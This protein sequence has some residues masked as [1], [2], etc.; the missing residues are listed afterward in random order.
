VGTG[1]G[2]LGITAKLELPGASVELLDLDQE[3]LGVAKTNVDL[4]TLDISVIQ[5]DLLKGS[6]SNY[7]VLLCNLPYV[8]DDYEINT[9]ALHEPR[10]AIFG[11]P[12]GLDLY[13]KLFKQTR[14]ESSEVLYIL[15]EALPYQHE[16]LQQIA[17]QHGFSL[18][19]AEGFIQI[20]EKSAA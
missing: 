20:F 19:G 17:S 6:S 11:G 8:P 2:A 13:R 3:A 14:N 15:T 12:D 1:S 10:L 9:A 16:Q 18:A 7:D 5:T 4:F